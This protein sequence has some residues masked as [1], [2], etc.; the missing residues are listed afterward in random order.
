MERWGRV[1]R[2]GGEEE[3]C[4][5]R[6]RPNSGH[7][8]TSGA[9]RVCRHLGS[10]GVAPTRPGWNRLQPPDAASFTKIHL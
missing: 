9:D 7:A 1:G 8:P 5:G 2:G 6:G 10:V 3:C 4:S